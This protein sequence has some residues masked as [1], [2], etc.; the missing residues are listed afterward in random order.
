MINIHLLEGREGFSFNLI[1]GQ[2]N[3][4]LRRIRK[5][6][7]ME[8]CGAGFSKIYFIAIFLKNL[9][10]VKNCRKKGW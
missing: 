2:S 7:I 5:G 1:L 10:V 4:S 3:I 8:I 6:G 9:A